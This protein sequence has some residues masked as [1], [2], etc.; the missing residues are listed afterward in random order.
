MSENSRGAYGT[1]RERIMVAATQ[2]VYRDGLRGLT[3]RAVAELAGAANSLI[4][5]HF[6]T[7]QRLLE[8]T[9]DWTLSESIGLSQLP[10]FLR[11][12]ETYVTALFDLLTAEMAI[13]VFQ[14]QM[15]LE[16]RRKAAIQEP[17]RLLYQRYIDELVGAMQETTSTTM[18][19]DTARYVFATL[20]GLVLQYVAGVDRRQI[21]RALLAFWKK[22]FDEH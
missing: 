7:R 3:F 2:V 16:S 20:D 21:E 14:Y 4:V 6:G 12:P 19:E 8:E 5:H 17:V 18:N 13:V 11:E 1:G 15:I 22:E 10:L 9:L